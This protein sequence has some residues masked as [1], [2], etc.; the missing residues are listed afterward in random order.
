MA[1]YPS[2]TE[3]DIKK[4]DKVK[5]S[6]FAKNGNSINTSEESFSIIPYSRI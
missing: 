5:H 4:S 2:H 1:N 6:L 3:F